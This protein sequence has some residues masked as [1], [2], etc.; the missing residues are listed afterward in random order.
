MKTLRYICYIAG[1]IFVPVL[2]YFISALIL[3]AIKIG[4]KSTTP[5]YPVYVVS[6]GI[7]TEFIF[8]LMKN[9][10]NWSEL[11]KVSDT[12]A[13]F[14]PRYLSIGWGNKRFFYEFQSWDQLTVEL[15]VSSVLLP[16][17][18]AVHTTF[19]AQL[20][21]YGKIYELRVSEEQYKALYEYIRS[22]F[23]DGVSTKIDDFNYEGTDAFYWGEGSYH[24][25][26]TCN[27]WT[28]QGLAAMNMPRPLWSPFRFGIE[29]ALE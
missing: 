14:L 2:C 26:N 10:V 25:F 16:S 1:A 4:D 7:H 28:R 23:K 8:D 13:Q 29:W 15:A 20:P 24:L 27:M 5:Q 3:G 19:L 11:T 6:A 22:S 12:K 18:T 21:T 17:P 9:P